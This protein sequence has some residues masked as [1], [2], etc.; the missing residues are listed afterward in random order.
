MKTDVY[1]QVDGI[2][3]ILSAAER[4]GEFNELSAQ[5]TMKLRLLTEEL[6]GLTV[7]LFDKLKYKFF[8]EKEGRLFTLYLSVDAQVEHYQ[9]TKLLSL[10]SDNE[11]I[12]E[13]GI[14][15][16]ISMIFEN[17]FNCATNN[18]PFAS[19]SMPIY[20]NEGA[21]QYFSLT[22]YRNQIPEKEREAEWDGLEKSII[23][24]MTDDVKIGVRNENVEVIATITF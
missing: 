24:Q 5:D 3:K 15:N 14:L 8:I 9:R 19:T 4:T 6:L 18:V 10:S 1:T 22:N 13:K 7:R 17:I 12:A 23:A 20:G 16:K 11:N 21:N 2:E